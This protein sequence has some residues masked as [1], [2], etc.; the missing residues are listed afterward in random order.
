MKMRQVIGLLLM[1]AGIA[2]L[3]AWILHPL[4]GNDSNLLVRSFGGAVLGGGA[5][6]AWRFLVKKRSIS[7]F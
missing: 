6:M 3:V 4:E 1:F 5:F 7:R 2:G